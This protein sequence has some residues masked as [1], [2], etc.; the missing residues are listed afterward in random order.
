MNPPEPPPEPDPRL[1]ELALGLADDV[2]VDWEGARNTAADL[3]ETLE[4]LREL[5]TLAQAH[6][7]DRRLRDSRPDAPVFRWGALEA[8]EKLGEGGFAEVWRAYEPA[9]AREV[10]LKLR[11]ADAPGGTRWLKEA[12]RLAKVRH[13]NVVQV[14]GADVFDGRPGLWTELVQGRTLEQRLLAEGPCGAAETAAIGIQ[15][16]AALAAVHAAGLVHGDVKTR[17]VMREGVPA[18]H[19]RLAGSGR[20]VLMDFG[21]ASDADERGAGSAGTP[22]FAA[23]ERLAGGESSVAGDLYSLGVVLYRLLTGRF[24]VEATS[25]DA[26]RAKLA[27]GELTPLR[28]LRP[29]LPSGLLQ[30]IERALERDAG[31]R[32]PGAAEME[33]ALISV[34]APAAAGPGADGTARWRFATGLVAGVLIT[35]VAAA[36][37]LQ[38]RDRLAP[39]FHFASAARPLPHVLSPLVRETESGQWIGMSSVR[40]G[41]LDGDGHADLATGAPFEGGAGRVHVLFG[42]GHGG[43]PRSLALAGRQT[44]AMFGGALAAADLNGD[45]RPDLAVGASN[46]SGAS[47]GGGRVLIYYGG[48]PFDSARHRTLQVAH[49]GAQFG[50]SLSCGD[51][52]GDGVADLAVGACGD[53]NAGRTPAGRVYV[54]FGGPR[55]HDSPDVTLGSDAPDAQFGNAVDLGGDLNGDGI[56]DL[57][58][59]APWE[60]SDGLR[61][62]RG[63]V[64]FGGRAPVTTPALVLRGLGPWQQLG[65][66]HYV[67]D[68]DGDGFDD[69]LVANERGDGFEHA[70]GT[71][72]LFRGAS[73]P[74]DV[75]ARTYRG[76]REGDGFGRWATN[77]G[78][79][80]G[81]GRADLA[82]AAWWS[83]VGGPTSGAIYLYAGGPQLDTAPLARLPGPG[84]GARFGTAIAGAGDL[85]DDGFPDVLVGEPSNS[86][87]WRGGTFL[88]SFH[89]FVLSRP[90]PDE[91]WRGGERAVVAWRGE[92]PAALEYS[93]DGRAW[94]TLLGHTGGRGSNSVSIRVP[95]VAD[96]LLDLRLRPADSKLRGAIEVAVPVARGR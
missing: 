60:S 76:E 67:G 29:D 47:P 96:T 21:A 15:V 64:F 28:S 53:A 32:F 37:F 89:R 17:N 95:Q 9:L 26:L 63:Y 25:T 39:R 31:R 35:L 92:T 22:M 77:V 4:Q 11:R 12:Q 91:R 20:V 52:N 46:W 7:R 19:G 48:A 16:C 80:N 93:A 36:A 34:L 40:I 27:R 38:V 90:R 68:L 79:V 78:D 57:A 1:V 61:A 71:A 49:A 43:F 8:V 72:L 6:R 13:P 82:I 94:T 85:D 44:S 2:P 86:S 81:D 45:G 66:P 41:D 24:P 33:R 69:L 87:Q 75:P 14:Y 83:D 50:F 84:V 3:S 55:M 88:A 56:A 74:S 73:A 42:D 59:S 65:A 23:P 30:V 54:Y 10:A 70:S 5:E 18:G 58:V 62:G 51:F